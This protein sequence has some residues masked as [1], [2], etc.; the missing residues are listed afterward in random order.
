MEWNV[1]AASRIPGHLPDGR[2]QYGMVRW[3]NGQ[4]FFW[5]LIYR[6]LRCEENLAF[7]VCR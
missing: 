1:I 3:G 4:P 6:L 7:A 2:E 5:R